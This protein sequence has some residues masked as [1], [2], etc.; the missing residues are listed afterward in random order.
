MVGSHHNTKLCIKGSQR[1]GGENHWL[2]G[3]SSQSSQHWDGRE[4]LIYMIPSIKVISN[5]PTITADHKKMTYQS[6][7]TLAS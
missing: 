3:S 4:A 5:L 1:Q 2:D 7:C 6:D